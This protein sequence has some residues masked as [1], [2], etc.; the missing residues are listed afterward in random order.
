MD[1]L[2]VTELRR[3]GMGYKTIAK[4]TGVDLNRV[5]YLC[6]KAGLSGNVT[7]KGERL[8]EPQVKEY[9]NLNGFDYVDGFTTA[10][11]PIRVR[12]RKCGG[13]FERSFHIFRDVVNGTWKCENECPLCKAKQKEERAKEKE[14]EARTKAEQQAIKAREL[15]AI[16]AKEKAD[17]I[18]RQTEKRL[19]IR[20]CRNCGK[21]YCIEATGYDSSK[22]CSELCC[23]RW[24]MRVKRDRRIR[25]MNNREH[26]NDITLE[27]LFDRD[28]GICRL[29]GKPCDRN[30]KTCGPN[31]PSIDHIIPISKGGKHVWDNV[32]LAHR[33]CNIAKRDT[34]YAPGRF[35]KK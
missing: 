20:V 1:E 22:Y 2:R 35:F 4:M 7:G 10:K 23:K 5:G 29:C 3:Q 15:A 34:I 27:K 24:N 31:Y 6:R 30:D 21:E 12:C 11:A 26:D 18:S 28:K 9:V 16:K 17:L 32:Q 14:H 8:T 19:A 33:Q 13:V 25:R